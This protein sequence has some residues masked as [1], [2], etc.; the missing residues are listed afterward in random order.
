MS[1]H[2]AAH[3]R[4]N[5]KIYNVDDNYYKT[6]NVGMGHFNAIQ[7]WKISSGGSVTNALFT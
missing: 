7:P 2:G 1:E 4:R 5:L 3:E 6:T